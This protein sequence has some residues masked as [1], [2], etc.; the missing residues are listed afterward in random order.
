MKINRTPIKIFADPSRVIL[1]NLGLP[2]KNRVEN[3]I[4]RISI[5]TDDEVRQQLEE[6]YN[7][8]KHRHRDFQA[9][10]LQNFEKVQNDYP[11]VARFNA[12]KALLLGACFTHE[13]SIEAAAL[14]NPS[15]VPH[16]D[17]SGL[18]PGEKR[19]VM[20]LRATGEGHISSIEFRGGVVD[21][22]GNISLDAPGEF[23]TYPGRDL[24][25]SIPKEFI[26]RR[27]AYH[28]G[29]K[30]EVLDVFP[31]KF[32]RQEF[33]EISSTVNEKD[34]ILDKRSLGIMQDIL[35]AN[36]TVDF[37]AEIPLN[38]RVLFPD[39]PVETLGM[40][41][42][43]L[44]EFN[45]DEKTIYFGTYTAWNGR[46]I[47][48]QFIETEDFKHFSVRAFYGP[49]IQDK[50]LAIFPEKI[51]GKYAIASRQ[52]GEIN[53]IMY[54]E[55]FYYWDEFQFLMEPDNKYETLQMGNCGSPIK[56]E[57]G[58]LLITHGVGPMRRYT[59]GA[60]LLDGE[61]PSKVIG[62][63]SSPLIEP[64]EDEREGYVPN[65]VYSCGSML[66]EDMLYIPYAMSDAKCGIGWVSISELLDNLTD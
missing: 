6:N 34:E 18:Q 10:L 13:Y 30:T 15:M 1:R 57:K 50:N 52:G 12:D 3:I 51:N 5:L 40:E 49:A 29:F 63:T 35:D 21:G 56:T 8:F 7:L 55:D 19:F 31:E 47:K 46:V 11:D 4:R 43:R 65:V 32:T 2:G 66:H 60:A 58:W 24:E 9:S 33:H 38:E 28:G 59:I 14:F 26:A 25:S 39:S 53:F 36:Y 42:L 61:N 64:L 23:A 20:S 27:A 62:R 44:V 16:P 48:P 17:Q 45:E 41:D 54:S 22:N 37:D